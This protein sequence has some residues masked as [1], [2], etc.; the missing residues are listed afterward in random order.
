MSRDD[1]AEEVGWPE[2]V[3][4]VS[5]A[6]HDVPQPARSRTAIVASNYGEAGAIDRWG[7]RLGLPAVVS[8]HVSHRY[9]TPSPKTMAAT[10]AIVVGFDGRFVHE[11]CRTSTVVARIKNRAGVDNEEA[12]SA[13]RRCAVRGD[14]ADHWTSLAS[15]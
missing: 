3:R 10:E 14:I 4:T 6:W 7:P 8:G 13:V 2:L 11:L 9:W 15:D 12:G 1:Y 5:D